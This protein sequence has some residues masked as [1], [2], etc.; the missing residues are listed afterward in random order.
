LHLSEA[1]ERVARLSRTVGTG[2]TIG[3]VY[4]S[5]YFQRISLWKNILGRVSATIRRLE[6]VMVELR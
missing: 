6:A 4:F 3:K 2:W 1:T 5:Q